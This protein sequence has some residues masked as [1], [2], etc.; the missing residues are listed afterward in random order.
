MVL[1]LYNY[2]LDSALY[3]LFPRI[4]LLYV[5]WTLLLL[6]CSLVVGILLLPDK[7]FGLLNSIL[8]SRVKL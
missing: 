6:T 4:Q 1:C 7:S 5:R 8:D 2:G 3:L